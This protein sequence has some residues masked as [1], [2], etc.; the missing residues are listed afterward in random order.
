MPSQAELEEIAEVTVNGMR[1]M[2]DPLLRRVRRLEAQVAADRKML[3]PSHVERRAD[4]GLTFY[5]GP[6]GTP[7]EA[8]TATMSDAP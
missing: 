4:G 1:R 5:Y 8:P 7:I 3:V 2:I 6:R